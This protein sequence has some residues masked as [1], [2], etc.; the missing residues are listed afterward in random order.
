MGHA[1]LGSTQQVLAWVFACW[2]PHALFSARNGHMQR[3][4]F[5][6][7]PQVSWFV[8]DTHTRLPRRD[9]EHTAQNT[10]NLGEFC[11]AWP[12]CPRLVAISISTDVRKEHHFRC[13][14]FVQFQNFPWQGSCS[15]R[16]FASFSHGNITVTLL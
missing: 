14:A 10:P 16:S 9:K 5:P 13:L 11:P 12:G 6:P 15:E 2:C 1:T 7:Y 8:R 3:L 4:M